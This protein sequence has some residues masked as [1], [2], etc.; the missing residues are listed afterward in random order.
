MG[1]NGSGAFNISIAIWIRGII[2]NL[3][4]IDRLLG[5]IPARLRPIAARRLGM[6]S[7][8]A[9]DLRRRGIRT[10]TSV[11]ANPARPSR[12]EGGIGPAGWSVEVWHISSRVPSISEIVPHFSKPNGR[13]RTFRMDGNGH[14]RRSGD[15]CGEG[16]THPRR[17]VIFCSPHLAGSCAL[18]QTSRWP[19][20]IHSGGGGPRPEHPH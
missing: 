5:R 1:Q 19:P 18:S 7:E 2:A 4:L 10:A 15:P 20:R 6:A 12:S 9:P 13:R 3:A 8:P 14:T 17:E 16:R 11:S